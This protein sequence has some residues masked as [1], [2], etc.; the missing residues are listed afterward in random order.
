M[1]PL[2]LFA[3]VGALLGAG[4]AARQAL[5]SAQPA[6]APD[7]WT[8]SMTS[9]LDNLTQDS[10]A[11]E[12]RY[13]PAV[14]AAERANGIP[15]GLLGRLLYQESRYRTDIITGQVKSS[16]GALGI[17]QFMP[18]TAVEMGVDPLDPVQAINGSARYLRRLYDRFGDWRKALAAYNF[19][20]GNVAKGREWPTETKNYVAQ[21]AAD[22]G[23]A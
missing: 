1:R 19:G 2:Y 12:A 23:L 10:R 5:A 4:L 8:D 14:E 17:A 6:D 15:A 20:Q 22:V 16:V 21:I 13:R 3:I 7:L 11:N 9:W 18:A